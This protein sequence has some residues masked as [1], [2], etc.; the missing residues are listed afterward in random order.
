MAGA[1]NTHVTVFSPTRLLKSDF[2]AN[3][4]VSKTSTS[5]KMAFVTSKLCLVFLFD[6]L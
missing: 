3:E 4:A 5:Q 1:S 6:I 2:R